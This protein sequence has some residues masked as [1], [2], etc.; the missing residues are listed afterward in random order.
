MSEL[1]RVM[2]TKGEP[3]SKQGLEGFGEA[4]EA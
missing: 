4:K 3:A 1:S 2:D